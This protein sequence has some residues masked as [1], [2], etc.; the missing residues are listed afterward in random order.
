VR[1]ISTKPVERRGRISIESRGSSRGSS[2]RSSTSC[3]IAVTSRSA[4]CGCPWIISQRGL[5]GTWRRTNMI[6][7]ASVAPRKNASR[8]PTSGPNSALSS[9]TPESAAPNAAPSQ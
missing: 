8:Q 5:S 1:A 9:S 3:S 7:M 4:S 6:P 2:M